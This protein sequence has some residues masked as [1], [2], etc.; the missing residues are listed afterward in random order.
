MSVLRRTRSYVWR[1]AG[2]S[3][4]YPLDGTGRAVFI[5]AIPGVWDQYRQLKSDGGLILA[6]L[7]RSGG[8]ARCRILANYVMRSEADGE[9][10]THGDLDQVLRAGR[11]SSWTAGPTIADRDRAPAS[12]T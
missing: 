6:R 8:C 4:A 10:V 2:S 11:S 12:A 1:V 9:R 3:N 7:G 5:F